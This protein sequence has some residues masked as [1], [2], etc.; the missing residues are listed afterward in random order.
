[1]ADTKKEAKQKVT[2]SIDIAVYEAYRDYC[3]ENAF[4]LS[5]KV[6]NYMK[7]ELEEA[8]EKKK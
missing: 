6:E 2:L 1:M 4:M 5:K 3:D 7:K 8:K